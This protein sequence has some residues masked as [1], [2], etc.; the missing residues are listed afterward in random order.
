MHDCVV[1]RHDPVEQLRVADVAVHELDAV[2]GKTGDVLDVA[3]VG[4]SVQHGHVH[5]RMVVDHVMHEVRTDET[6]ATGHDDVLGSEKFFRY[7][8]NTTLSHNYLE[9]NNSK[10]TPLTLKQMH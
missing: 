6:A 1:A 5:V 2:F 3:R 7:T 4:Q 8:S 10:R 9:G